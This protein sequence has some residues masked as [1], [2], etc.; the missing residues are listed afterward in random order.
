VECVA[1]DDVDDLD[2]DGAGE[3]GGRLVSGFVV[4]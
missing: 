4:A 3:T 1:I 2:G